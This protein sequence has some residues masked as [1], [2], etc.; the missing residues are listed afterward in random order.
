MANTTKCTPNEVSSN[1]NWSAPRTRLKA[2]RSMTNDVSTATTITSGTV[3]VHDQPASNAQ[4]A[5]YPD[6]VISSP[7]AKLRRCMTPK[8]TA[9]PRAN[10][11]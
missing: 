10:R 4:N 8:T 5:A 11:A 7:W 1:V 3:R 9:T 6:T 2:T